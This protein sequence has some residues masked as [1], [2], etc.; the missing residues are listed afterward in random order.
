MKGY[1]ANFDTDS[2][3]K[4]SD[5]VVLCQ[6]CNYRFVIATTRYEVGSNPIKY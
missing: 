2:D 4:L 3:E 1:C 6:V 5:T